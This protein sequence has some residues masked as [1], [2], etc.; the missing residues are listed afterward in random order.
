M[1]AQS[2]KEVTI[3]VLAAENYMVFQ[4]IV[5]KNPSCESFLFHFELDNRASITNS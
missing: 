1:L 4:L 2:Q 5:N 3:P